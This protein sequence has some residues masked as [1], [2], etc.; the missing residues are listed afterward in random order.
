MAAEDKDLE[1]DEETAEQASACPLT[2]SPTR[3]IPS[4][5]KAKRVRAD[6]ESD[7]DEITQILVEMRKHTAL[8][9]VQSKDITDIKKDVV[10]IKTKLERKPRKFH[11]LFG[12]VIP[13]FLNY[14]EFQ[15]LLLIGNL[16]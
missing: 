12:M 10:D 9:Q 13:Q 11:F 16:P 14:E 1:I 7:D 2:Q 5:Q 3:N 6:S 4:L 15:E 8:L